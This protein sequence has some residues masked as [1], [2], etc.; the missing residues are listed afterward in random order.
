MFLVA[1]LIWL[2]YRSYFH[3]SERSNRRLLF[4]EDAIEVK[5]LLAF[6]LEAELIM[7]LESNLNCAARQIRT[8]F[9]TE[10][11][12]KIGQFIFFSV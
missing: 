12:I 7:V 10:K 9:D 5:S 6:S 2:L 1:D 3:G 4:F 8:L 11:K